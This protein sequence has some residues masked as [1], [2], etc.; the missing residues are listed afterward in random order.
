MNNLRNKLKKPILIFS[1][2]SVLLLVI[3]LTLFMT[4]CSG[5]IGEIAPDKIVNLL[6]P[7][8]WV[9][10]AQ[11]ISMAIV[12]CLILFFIWK[13]TNKMLEK[14]KQLIQK[15]INEGKE[16]KLQA[17][18]ELADVKIMH[19]Q[20]NAKCEKMIND[21][22]TKANMMVEQITDEARNEASKIIKTAKLQADK[23]LKQARYDAEQEI[24]DTAIQAAHVLMK[25]EINRADNQ[26]IVRDFIKSLDNAKQ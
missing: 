2:T 6:F 26:K 20:A 13:P 18:K 3:S 1:L 11:M 12:F 16:L 23:D 5:E 15:E 22:N 14:R 24:I 25:K 7:S 10:V 21:A 19:Q 9:F 4:S 17:E 8:L